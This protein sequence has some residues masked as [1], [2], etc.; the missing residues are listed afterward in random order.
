HLSRQWCNDRWTWTTEWNN[1]VVTDESCFYLQHHDGRIRVWRHH[2][3]KLLNC[4]V[5]RRHIGPTA[6]IMV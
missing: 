4:C 5:M 6:G 1:I 3:E 2:D